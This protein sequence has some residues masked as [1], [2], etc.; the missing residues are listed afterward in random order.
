M[1]PLGVM[2]ASSNTECDPAFTQDNMRAVW[3]HQL[4]G[5]FILRLVKTIEYRSRPTRPTARPSYIYTAPRS[6][7]QVGEVA[8]PVPKAPAGLCGYKCVNGGHEKSGSPCE[9]W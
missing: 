3:T 9:F 4:H 6:T 1:E 8:R 5:E 2:W 7:G